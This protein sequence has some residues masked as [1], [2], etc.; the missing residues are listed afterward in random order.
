MGK[1]INLYVFIA[2]ISNKKDLVCLSLRSVFQSVFGWAMAAS[3]CSYSRSL[4]LTGRKKRK[5]RSY[6]CGSAA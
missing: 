3:G 5:K 2:V 6:N 1:R 4:S